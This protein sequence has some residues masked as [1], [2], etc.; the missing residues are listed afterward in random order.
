MPDPN[1]PGPPNTPPQTIT[2]PDP[3]PV[4]DMRCGDCGS[5]LEL[6]VGTW[7]LYWRCVAHGTTGCRGHIGA[8]RDSGKP[9]GIPANAETRSARQRVHEAFDLL[10]KYGDDG[11]KTRRRRAYAWLALLLGL[12]GEA[13]IS[14]MDLATCTLVLSRLKGLPPGA[15]ETPEVVARA[16]EDRRTR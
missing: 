9:L 12:E 4:T 16:E 14:N 3:L 15:L 13:H 5:A 6:L 2:L 7:G 1:P 11:R 10:W 8:H